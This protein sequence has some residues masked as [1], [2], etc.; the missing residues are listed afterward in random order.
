MPQM[1]QTAEWYAPL[2]KRAETAIKSLRK[3]EG[4]VRGFLVNAGLNPSD[5]H[6][7]SDLERMYWERPYPNLPPIDTSHAD[8][9]VAENS[10]SSEPGFLSSF[11]LNPTNAGFPA[12]S[13]YGRE[14]WIVHE[15]YRILIHAACISFPGFVECL[16]HTKKSESRWESAENR[17][18]VLTRLCS[19]WSGVHKAPISRADSILPSPQGDVV[20][21]LWKAF[22]SLIRPHPI[23]EDARLVHPSKM[24]SLQASFLAWKAGV[25]KMPLPHPLRNEPP[26]CPESL[27]RSPGS[28]FGSADPEFAAFCA[29]LPGLLSATVDAMI[30]D[31]SLEWL[32]H[33]YP[34]VKPGLK[35]L[36]VIQ[37]VAE[38]IDKGADPPTVSGLLNTLG[39]PDAEDE[40]VRLALRQLSTEA[41]TGMLVSG[42]AWTPAL[43]DHLPDRKL[44][45]LL[46]TILGT[47]SEDL[48]PPLETKPLAQSNGLK[49]IHPG[50]STSGFTSL[51]PFFDALAAA[52]A[53]VIKKSLP[54][55]RACHEHDETLRYV[56]LFSNVPVKKRKLDGEA[57]ELFIRL[58]ARI[59][60]RNPERNKCLQERAR[61]FALGYFE[62]ASFKSRPNTPS[63]NFFRDCFHAAAES[64][65]FKSYQVAVLDCASRWL[66]EQLLEVDEI[67]LRKAPEE[68]DGLTIHKGNRLL[69][70][71]PPKLR[72][73][74][75][76]LA[77]QA[78]AF[79]LWQAALIFTRPVLDQY[80][81]TGE[82]I[83]D[84]DFT[85][86]FGY[87]VATSLR[88]RLEVNVPSAL[89]REIQKLYGSSGSPTV[90]LQS[91][92]TIV[93]SEP[94]QRLEEMGWENMLGKYHYV[95]INSTYG[96]DTIGGSITLCLHPQTRGP[97]KEFK[98][99]ST[100]SNTPQDITASFT[101]L[102][103]P[104]TA[105]PESDARI[106]ELILSDLSTVFSGK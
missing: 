92:G 48:L 61:T 10:R 41:I 103:G 63:D 27:C 49:R 43:L 81:R 87:P 95:G 42:S 60:S 7:D 38:A 5:Q 68:A 84:R 12:G 67:I 36:V 15:A 50:R 64:A 101:K 83:E 55:I 54:I 82:L 69:K 21:D 29:E 99:G 79:C 14:A 75:R 85:D 59:P 31:S 78:E 39:E 105:T 106:L 20:T 88:K 47:F 33:K 40:S 62:E 94:F 93:P 65:G 76:V 16:W 26:F 90:A 74:E 53:S 25:W 80:L 86:V 58:S 30:Q 35:D 72:A 37:R 57:S 13:V 22:E 1:S 96:L 89:D 102:R 23:G 34:G 77:F 104:V 70:N 8:W 6:S 66:R 97:K 98:Q 3:H 44:A 91:L 4:G 18:E 100:P 32:F 51:Q 19:A 2:I 11:A 28:Q 73:D 71:L 9:L 24:I 17:T 52:P 56:S 46:K 45:E